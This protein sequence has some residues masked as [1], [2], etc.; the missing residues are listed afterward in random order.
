VVSP[1]PNIPASARR[2][3]PI[4]PIEPSR[5]RGTAPLIGSIPWVLAEFDGGERLDL[6]VEHDREVLNELSGYRTR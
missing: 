2:P 1:T 3:S 5:A 4:R 6:A